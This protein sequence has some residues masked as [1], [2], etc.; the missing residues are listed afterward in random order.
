MYLLSIALEMG[1]MLTKIE[2]DGTSLTLCELQHICIHQLT[3]QENMM[4]TNVKSLFRN[5]IKSSQF[6]PS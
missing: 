4:N 3:A 6:K 1:L 5:G 2:D